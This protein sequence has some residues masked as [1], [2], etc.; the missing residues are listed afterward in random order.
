MSAPDEYKRSVQKSA[1][2]LKRADTA[3]KMAADSNHRG[4]YEHAVKIRKQAKGEMDSANKRVKGK[5]SSA[6]RYEN[7]K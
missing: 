3:V 5:R 2:N 6:K 4:T 1:V 7:Q